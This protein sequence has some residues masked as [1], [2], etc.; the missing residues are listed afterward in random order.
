LL[1]ATCLS[2]PFLIELYYKQKMKKLY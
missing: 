2:S 1:S